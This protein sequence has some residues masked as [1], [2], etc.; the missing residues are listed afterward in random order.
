MSQK[1]SQQEATLE[2]SYGQLGT[3]FSRTTA[4]TPVQ[5]PQW[6]AFNHKLA[7]ALAL[8]ATL[9]G[10]DTS[11]H[12]FSG[13]LDASDWVHSP[14]AKAIEPR[15][16]AYAGHQF[17][18]FVPQ[19]GDGR[20]L[21]LTEVVV[22][23]N[24]D[25][26]VDIQLKGSGPTAFSRGGDGR[27]PIGP[28][29]REYL[30]SEAMHHL[31]VPTTRALAA[32]ASGEYVYRDEP[33]PGAI[34]TRVASSHIRIGTFQY[35]AAHGGTAQVK[36]LA[37]YAIQRHFPTLLEEAEGAPRYLAFLQH[38]MQRQA[39]LVAEWERVGFVHGVMNTDN[40]SICGETIDYGPCAFIDSF[41]KD[42]VF[43]SIDRNGRYRFS[44]QPRIAQW[45][46]ARFAE[47]L[48]PLIDES[49]MNTHKQEVH[50]EQTVARLTDIIQQFPAMYKQA[51]AV[52]IGRKF[53]VSDPDLLT[54]EVS[55]RLFTLIDACYAQLEVDALDHTLSFAA[56]TTQGQQPKGDF[57]DYVQTTTSLSFWH[58]WHQRW[59]ALLD[60]AQITNAADV[61]AQANPRLIP[62]NHRIQQVIEQVETNGDLSEFW[63]CH[64]AWSAPYRYSE[65]GD[66]A[67]LLL[68]PQ[69]DEQVSRTFCGT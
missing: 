53:G 22:P 25:Q 8:P 42:T 18:H 45:N 31:G 43:S 37:D 58:D 13:N 50:G 36:K 9:R 30:V 38:V 51:R 16:L 32:V 60:E 33:L 21:L 49:R 12:L 54:A 69:P 66:H 23:G 57:L 27:S 39:H 4:P 19:L 41:S 68:P 46:L 5:A 17:G 1:V 2:H 26:R 52:S 35:A 40:T 63:R 24:S 59:L 47:T 61:M 64:G 14:L 62:R 44:N 28:V 3:F 55:E 20:A 29:L 7:E 11:L 56:L 65:L 6:I 48:L 34:L 67:D 15:A 10:T